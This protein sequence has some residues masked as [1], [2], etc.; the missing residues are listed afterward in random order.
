MKKIAVIIV[1]DVLMTRLGL[2]HLLGRAD[3]VEIIT[4]AENGKQFLDL[5]AIHKPHVVLMDVKMPVMDGLEATKLAMN[6]YPSLKIIA[7]TNDDTE[8]TIEKMMLSGA[9]GFL[10]KTVDTKELTK[11]I[12]T[13]LSGGTYFSTELAKQYNK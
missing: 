12:E 4:E 7:L 8:T 11:A 10:F 3:N 1:D 9:R 13:V 6:K 5:M 2:S